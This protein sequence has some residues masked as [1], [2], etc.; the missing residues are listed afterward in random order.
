MTWLAPCRALISAR[1]LQTLETLADRLAATG[2]SG[3]DR[4][5]RWTISSSEIAGQYLAV[6]SAPRRKVTMRQVNTYFVISAI[7][8]VK[9]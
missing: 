4:T 5:S 9:S 2:C 3:R 7:G 6:G 8:E 1:N